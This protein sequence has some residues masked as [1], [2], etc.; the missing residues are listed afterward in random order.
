MYELR[1]ITR[2]AAAHRLTM[3][4]EKC[5]NLHGHNWR[6]EVFVRGDR[7]DGGGVLLDFGVI[8]SHVRDLMKEL[9]HK[10]LNELDYFKDGT[11][12]SSEHIARFIAES[13]CKSMQVPGI[14]VS[15]VTAWESEDACA[16]YYPGA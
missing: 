15:R 6:V 4:G 10:Y 3:V 7:L 16:T 12:P 14:A 11:P 1:V 9:D 8:K 13:L 5:E 2:F